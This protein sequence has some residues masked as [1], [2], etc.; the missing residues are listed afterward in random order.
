MEEAVHDRHGLRIVP[1]QVPRQEVN[2]SQIFLSGGAGSIDERRDTATS[3]GFGGTGLRA[4]WES[5]AE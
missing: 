1:G 3:R 5:K 4:R 2:E